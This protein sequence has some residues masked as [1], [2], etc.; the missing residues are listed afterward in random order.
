MA[1]ISRTKA[2]LRIAGDDLIPR[3]ITNLLGHAPTF[4]QT[5]G[6]IIV[7][8]N[9]GKEREVTFGM[10][11]LHANEAEPGDIDSQIFEILDKLTK[12]LTIWQS[13]SARYDIDLFCGLFMEKEIEGIS[14]YPKALSALGERGI[15]IGFDIYGP[16]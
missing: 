15:E 11:R 12:D 10:R 5:K 1:T 14:I 8:K 2:S 4:E 13:L 6:Q 16:D 3:E 9:T 7:G